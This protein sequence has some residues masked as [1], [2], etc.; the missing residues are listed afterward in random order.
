[1]TFPV[2]RDLTC[3]VSSGTEIIARVLIDPENLSGHNPFKRERTVI[4]HLPTSLAHLR[5]KRNGACG[6]VYSV[7]EVRKAFRKKPF[8]Y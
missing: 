7:V 6:A 5:P 8:I 1:L 3:Q 4:A 2:H